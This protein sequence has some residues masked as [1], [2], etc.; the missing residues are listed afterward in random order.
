MLYLLIPLI[1]TLLIALYIQFQRSKD[2]E[3]TE[4]EISINNLPSEFQGLK[5]AHIS[6]LHTSKFGFRE[7]KIIKVCREE[8][9]DIILITGDFVSNSYGID[10]CLK[11]MRDINAPMGVWAVWGNNDNNLK[12]D[13]LEKGLKKLG[14]NILVNENSLLKKDKD[15]IR[16]I[17]VDDPYKRKDDLESAMKG[18]KEDEIKILLAH[19]PEIFPKSW[20]YKTDL[21]LAGHT[22][23]GQ[24]RF[25]LIGTVYNHTWN[26]VKYSGGYFKE[27]GTQMYVSRGLGMSVIPVRY[28]CPAELAILTLKKN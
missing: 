22:H 19:S 23:G 5:I 24:I 13:R 28:L 26:L 6:D 21:V 10:P 15:C 12:T 18:V 9:P 8:K 17:G 11:T 3:I 25:P 7:E 1:I 27:K 16:L 20:K 14:F 2:F 4:L